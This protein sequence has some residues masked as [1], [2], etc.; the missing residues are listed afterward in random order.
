[1][2]KKALITGIRGGRTGRIRRSCFLTEVIGRQAE[3]G[4]DR[5]EDERNSV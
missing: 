4:F 2:A 3:R 1:M 5:V